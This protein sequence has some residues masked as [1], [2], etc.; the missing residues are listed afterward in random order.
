MFRRTI[1]K[2]DGQILVCGA[3]TVL[4]L[5]AIAA[6]TIDIGYMFK[7]QADMQ[8]GADAAAVAAGGALVQ[9]RSAGDSEATCQAAAQAEAQ[10][11]AAYNCPD[12]RAE[13]K[14][15]TYQDGSFE[16]LTD[17]DGDGYDDDTGEMASAIGVKLFRDETSS[18]GPLALFF[19]SLAGH[20]S[21]NMKT[22]GLVDIRYNI[23]AIGNDLRPF[24]VP[25]AAVSG[26]SPGDSFTINLMEET[27]VDEDG[28]GETDYTLAPGNFGWLN[29]DGGSLG[30][31]EL[32][33]WIENGYPELFTIDPDVGH[34]WIDGMTGLRSSLN[35]PIQ[36]VVG[37][38][39]FMCVFDTVDG[40]GSTADF[41][42][43][44][45]AGVT[46]DKAILNG[47]N[48]RIDCTFNRLS[49][50]PV[51]IT[52][53]DGAEDPSENLCKITLVQ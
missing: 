53:G 9:G 23:Y 43:V 17:S 8:N 47:K 46:I 14:F 22:A 51:C 28:D 33:E 5:A 35:K 16:P 1:K 24:A 20:D 39:L 29:M 11:F 6:L 50:V 4:A 30:T 41:R 31:P 18:G 37:K 42:I 3:L 40:E 26:L 10:N 48:S 27:E 12:A 32:V 49:Y 36:D 34:I 25:S 45:F 15:G 44:R 13:V 38:K 7:T 21:V 19:A 52:D 2:R